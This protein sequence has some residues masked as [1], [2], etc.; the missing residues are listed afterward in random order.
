MKSNCGGLYVTKIWIKEA[1][2]WD[3]LF[4]DKDIYGKGHWFPA[5]KNGTRVN[6][7]DFVENYVL[8]IIVYMK[9]YAI[10]CTPW[11]HI[12]TYI[13]LNLRMPLRYFSINWKECKGQG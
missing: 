3:I 9:K 10:F 6:T 7:K 2:W 4:C 8:F 5:N 12:D 1:H 13:V 11:S